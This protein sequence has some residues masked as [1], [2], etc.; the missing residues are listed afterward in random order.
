MRLWGTGTLEVLGARSTWLW[1]CCSAPHPS[2]TCAPSAWTATGQ[3]R[4]RWATTWSGHRSASSPWSRWCGSYLRSSH[5]LLSSWPNTT[6][7]SVS[8]TMRPGTSSHPAWCPSSPRVSSWSWFTVRSTKWPSS[9][10][11]PSSWPRTVWR[12]SPPSRRPASSG[13]TGPETE[14]PSSQDSSNHQQL[15]QGELDDIDLEESCCPSDTKPRN[16]RFTKR[17]KVEGSD[18]CPPQSCRLSWASA[19]APQLYPEQKTPGGATP[20][21]RGQQDQSGPDAGEALHLRAGGGDGGVRALLVPLL[22]HVQ[23]P[24]DLQRQLLHPGGTFQPVLL[25]WLLQQLRESHNIH[26]F[27]QG[28]QEK[29]Q[30]NCMRESQA[31]ITL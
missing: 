20:G 15:G 19:R 27:Q 5:S 6:S 13:R 17:R 31:H 18:C 23:P 16:H 30:E 7:G 1:T 2:C 22:L 10:P 9:A 28:F 8:W 26:Y 4:R 21:G 3:S 14:S 25:D 11:P 24:R 29:L 12:G